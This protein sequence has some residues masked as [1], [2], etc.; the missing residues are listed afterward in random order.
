MKS[1]DFITI[2]HVMSKEHGENRD[3]I[4]GGE[5]GYDPDF[6]FKSSLLLKHLV[7]NVFSLF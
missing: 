3:P 1:H 5:S 7:C 4:E 2:P 6:L